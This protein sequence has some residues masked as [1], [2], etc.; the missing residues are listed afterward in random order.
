[1][2]Q[3]TNTPNNDNPAMDIVDYSNHTFHMKKAKSYTYNYSV[4]DGML[5][6]AYKDYTI[7]KMASIIR[8]P[9]N[10]IAYR[11]AFLQKNHPESIVFKRG[12]TVDKGTH[13][14]SDVGQSKRKVKA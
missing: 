4:I 12:V 6:E 14:V 13:K 7:E 9:R 3:E 10:R 11:I 2:T 1:M 5:I 8:E